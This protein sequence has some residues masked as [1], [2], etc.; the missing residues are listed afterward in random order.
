MNDEYLPL[1][2][3][4]I[5]TVCALRFNGYSYEDKTGL[6][7]PDLYQP[8]KETLRM[9]EDQ[10]KNFAVFF[11]LQR[12]LGKW[13]GEQ[14]TKASPDH[15]AY[16]LLYLHLYRIEAPVEYAHPDYVWKWDAIKPNK[17]EDVAQYIRNSLCRKG[18]EEEQPS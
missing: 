2:I 6:K 9:H 17:R 12:F 13:G 3:D 15:M 18:V 5:L 11:A 16:D 8:I 7:L 4:E 10:L 1:E 14:L